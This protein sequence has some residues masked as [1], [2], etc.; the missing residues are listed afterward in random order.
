MERPAKR[1]AASLSPAACL[2]EQAGG[3]A[4]QRDPGDEENDGDDNRRNRQTKNKA[5]AKIIVRLLVDEHLVAASY[6]RGDAA[7]GDHQNQRGDNGLDAQPRH[8]QT[9]DKSAQRADAE[10]GREH[11]RKGNIAMRHD[12]RGSG[13]GNRHD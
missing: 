12:C 5:I 4:A 1:L 2:D 11:Q 9:V 7:T 6:K 13:S 10:A 8:Q 3:G